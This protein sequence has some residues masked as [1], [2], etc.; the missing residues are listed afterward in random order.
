MDQKD[1]GNN[2][3]LRTTARFFQKYWKL[4]AIFFVAA[5]ALSLVASFMITPR[6]KS[7]AILFPTNSMR[8]SKAILA[9][10]YS[11]DFLDYGSERDCEYAIQILSSQSMEDAVCQRFN[12]LVHYDIDPDDPH[13]LF[14]LHN[15]YRGNVSVKRTE[16]L[17]VEISVLDEDPAMAADIANFM[18]VYYDSLSSHIQKDRA[19]DAYKVMQQV[20]EEMESELDTLVEKWKGDKSNLGLNELISN[21]SKELAELQTRMA[22]TKVDMDQQVSFKFWLDKASPAD[23]KAYPKRAIVVLLGTLGTLLVCILALLVVE[24]LRKPEEEA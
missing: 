12:M 16:F 21:K 20:C 6:F 3:D 19:A 18:A 7:T 8:V 10:R 4:L 9:E 14:K 2:F 1:F 13:K 23:N 22:E 17:G 24:R 11:M 15:S 5:F